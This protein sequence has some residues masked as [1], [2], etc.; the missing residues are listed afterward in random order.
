MICLE[1]NG[2][3]KRNHSSHK[4]KRTFAYIAII[5]TLAVLVFLYF[6][7]FRITYAPELKND[8]NAIAAIGQYV[9]L[10]ATLF[11]TWK[12]HKR[13]EANEKENQA[14]QERFS[15]QDQE[16]QRLL[17]EKNNAVQ[18][19]V[20]A[21]Q[22]RNFEFQRRI[23]LFDR[24]YAVYHELKQVCANANFLIVSYQQRETP[25]LFTEP[26]PF[27]DWMEVFVFNTPSNPKPYS[28]GSEIR[29]IE[30][31]IYTLTKAAN[32]KP[33]SAARDEQISNLKDELEHLNSQKYIE[34]ASSVD[35]VSQ[36]LSMVEHLYQSDISEP[37]LHFIE[38]YT[39]LLTSLFNGEARQ[40]LNTFSSP[41]ME[42]LQES[43]AHLKDSHAEERMKELLNLSALENLDTGEEKHP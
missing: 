15:E 12:I 26:M 32:R 36:R 37:V 29:R 28:L 1:N 25:K 4:G 43:F 41:E 35:E 3:K 21:Q 8:W 31:R 22:D 11:L 16:F 34:S 17:S 2:D 40:Q 14:L 19:Q 38:A 6:L 24:R 27:A 10:V 7:G 42:C 13:T 23:D 39:T 18:L 5:V 30:A 33:F 20:A 9:A